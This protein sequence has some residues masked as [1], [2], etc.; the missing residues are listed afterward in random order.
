MIN[1]A[2]HLTGWRT[3]V[4]PTP[5]S[6]PSPPLP[7]PPHGTHPMRCRESCSDGRDELGDSKKCP[8]AGWSA[9]GM[10]TG[11]HRPVY[12]AGRRTRQ[13]A[14]MTSHRRRL[15]SERRSEFLPL[16]QSELQLYSAFHAGRICPRSLFS[17]LDRSGL[18]MSPFMRLKGHFFCHAVQAPVGTVE[19]FDRLEARQYPRKTLA[20]WMFVELGSCRA[21]DLFSRSAAF[22]FF[23]KSVQQLLY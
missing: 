15:R 9:A 5:S 4:P 16:L 23:F 20:G 2:R 10:G 1:L 6:P 3:N 7:L 14:T 22:F 13:G 8:H 21:A 17:I 19:L 12:C 11:A 18:R